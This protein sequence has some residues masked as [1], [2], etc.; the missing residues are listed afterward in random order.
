MS[1]L[2]TALLGALAA[3]AVFPAGAGAVENLANEPPF[4]GDT[5]PPLQRPPSTAQPPPGFR[6]SAAQA[7]ATAAR[8]SAVEAEGAP[9]SLRAT[10]YERGDDEWQVDFSDSSGIKVA[11]AIVV[12]ADG[13]LLGAWHD[14]QLDTPLARG[15]D[16][17]V[18][19]KVNAPYVWLLLCLLFIAPFFD[20]RRPFRLLHLDL[21]VLLAFGV[22]HYYFNRANISASTPLAYPVMVYLLLRALMIGFRPRKRPGPMVPIVPIQWLAFG[23]VFLLGFRIG[24][25]VFDSNVIDVG[26]A[27]VLGANRVAHGLS[28]YD[29]NLQWHPNTYGP[30]NYIAYVPFEWIWPNHGTWDSLPAAH[31]AAVAFDALTTWGL[32]VLGTRLREGT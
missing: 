14:E 7:V 27:G 8:A 23:V 32:Y 10:A 9:G 25:N 2:P 12:D 5:I 31:A 28:L 13:R 19:Q 6:L 3:I 15:Y 26:Y 21:L 20:R 1:R 29:W 24:L 22:S 17:A 30:V 4:G 18:A 16:G 11:E